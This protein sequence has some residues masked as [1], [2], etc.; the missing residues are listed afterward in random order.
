[1][2][3]HLSDGAA[4]YVDTSFS[5]ATGLASAVYTLSYQAA[6]SGQTLTITW[7][8]DGSGNLALDATT[9]R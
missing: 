8:N 4:D 7:T 1:M 2:V 9:L 3:A 6:S 5:A